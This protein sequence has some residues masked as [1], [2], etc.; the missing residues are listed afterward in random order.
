M[1]LTRFSTP[2]CCTPCSGIQTVQVPGAA[3][4]QGADGADGEDGVNAYTYT[5]AQFTMPDTID[6]GLGYTVDVSVLDTR[7]MVVGQILY[8]QNAGWMR[9]NAIT[10]QTTVTLENI[11]NVTTGAYD[12]NVAAATNIAAG[13][14]IAPGGMQGPAGV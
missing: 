10:N 6:S 7:W 8:V 1:A 11:E 3:G 9:V 2:S 5:S 14:K 12:E 4:V 13:S